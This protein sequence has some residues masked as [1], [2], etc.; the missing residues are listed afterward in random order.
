MR[1]IRLPT[2][3]KGFFPFSFEAKYPSTAITILFPVPIWLPA[4][5][6]HMLS[7][8]TLPTMIHHNHHKYRLRMPRIC[9]LC[10]IFFIIIMNPHIISYQVMAVFHCHPFFPKMNFCT[11]L[12]NFVRLYSSPSMFVVKI[13]CLIF[14]T[15]K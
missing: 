14:F 2:I 15:L 13:G 11:H 9:F 3:I 6:N 4:N 10:H 1:R 8:Q 5:N 7:I 12:L